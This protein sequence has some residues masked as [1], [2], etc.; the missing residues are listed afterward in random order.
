MA[1]SEKTLQDFVNKFAGVAD[2][3]KDMMSEFQE[4][5]QQMGEEL[6]N[7][8]TAESAK[9][10][11]KIKSELEEQLKNNPSSSTPAQ[12]AVIKGIIMSALGASSLLGSFVKSGIISPE[13]IKVTLN[14]EKEKEEITVPC[15]RDVCEDVA[16]SYRPSSPVEDEDQASTEDVG[17]STAVSEK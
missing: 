1:E 5:A 11:N 8:I 15:Y 4:T 13:D 10:E 3:F 9:V 7:V 16:Y 14:K 12:E 17:C 2:K 6:V